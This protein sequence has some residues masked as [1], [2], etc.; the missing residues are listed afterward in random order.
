MVTM[1]GAQERA[2]SPGAPDRLVPAGYS[3]FVRGVPVGR[4]E[5]TVATEATGTTITSTGR[6]SPPINVVLRRAEFKYRPDWTPE[7]LVLDVT[8]NGGDSMLR[9]TFTGN[10]AATEVTQQGQTSKVS[11][12]ISPQ[13]IA[14]P[15]NV[16]AGYVAVARRLVGATAGAQLRAYVVPAAEVGITVSSVSSE[17]AQIGAAFVDVRRFELTVANPNG[18]LTVS[19]TTDAGGD[20]IRVAVPSG[21]VDVIR[22]DLAASTSRVQVHS[23]PGDEPVIIP[24]TGFN[25]GATLTRPRAAAGTPTGAAGATPA[26]RL[27]AVV[28]LAGSAASDRDGVIA[29]IPVLAQLAGAIADAGF[30]A[31]RYDKR[32][33]GQSGGRA[34]S[35]TLQDYS[36]DVR[37]V[38]R[39]LAARKDVDPKR[40]AVIGHSEG[41]W[42]AIQAAARE[43][44]I[45][46]LVA[47]AG[48]ASSGAD[49]MLEQQ[50]RALDALKLAPADRE[51]RVA[52][53][54]Q[55]QGAV[56][57]GKGWDTI[58]P[59]MRRD[60]DTPWFQSLLAFTPA[61]VV[62]DVRQPTLF[63][64]GEIDRHV[65]VAHVTELSELA[66]NG[67]SRS[68]E[69]VV[70]RGVNHLMV[71]AVTG[72]PSEYGSLPDR[73]ISADVRTTI[74]GWLTRTFNTIK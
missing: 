27:P 65:P 33:F 14:L 9:T 8:A 67:R 63:V 41:A 11:H 20:L 17:R 43:N 74:T 23:N 54:K 26:A 56:L 57:S 29:G 66:R 4:E 70:I 36:E 15:N 40:I 61:K 73:S 22:D 51:Q 69:V 21:G 64:H 6:L 59:A 71:P 58:P 24:A 35:A 18:D 52:L 13:T 42:V 31:V 2:A 68:V 25:L 5:I 10:S 53:Q 38:V 45:A 47:I 60:A 49:L 28:L 16:F 3:I 30:I 12:Q 34:E 55:I 48:P 39:W 46:A 19:L 50:Q 32:G 62:D 44:K 7:L 1:A 37:A 72:E